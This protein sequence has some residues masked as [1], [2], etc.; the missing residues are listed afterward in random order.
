VNDT[1]QIVELDGDCMTS[2]QLFH[3]VFAKEFGFPSF[4]GENMDAWVDCMSD[5]DAPDSGMSKIHV[6]KGSVLTMQISNAK[7]MKKKAPE[8]WDAIN[9]CAAFVNWRRIEQGDP[10]ILSLSYSD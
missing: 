3:A 8:I 10:T 9:E 5:L 4:Y 6:A 1:S 2:W 7:K